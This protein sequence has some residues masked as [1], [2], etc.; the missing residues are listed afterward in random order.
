VSNRSLGNC[1]TLE[2]SRV[3]PRFPVP[4]G[5]HPPS[6]RVAK[7][8]RKQS[9]AGASYFT[10]R[11]GG[12][13]V[14]VVKSKDTSDSGEEIWSLLLSEAPPQKPDDKPS[15]VPP[16]NANPPR[17]NYERSLDDPIPF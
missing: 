1:Q 10:G 5:N 8:Y 9:K 16:P 11:W 4:R 3:T 17:T 14:A 7:L 13:K 2:Y 6:F 12:A 15:P